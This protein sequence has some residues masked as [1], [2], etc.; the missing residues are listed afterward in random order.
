[1]ALD[2]LIERFGSYF[3]EGEMVIVCWYDNAESGVSSVNVII[4]A[5]NECDL[6]KRIEMVKQIAYNMIAQ[7]LI[8][9]DILR[10]LL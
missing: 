1:M 4:G 5:R 7:T 3:R 9:A 6:V 2:S 10:E 8:L